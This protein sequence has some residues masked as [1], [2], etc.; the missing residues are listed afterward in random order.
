M[1]VSPVPAAEPVDVAEAVQK[2][3]PEIAAIR[4]RGWR[5][6]AISA[7]LSLFVLML[8]LQLRGES[9]FT[10]ILLSLA[11]LVI[12]IS[13]I[14]VQTRRNQEAIV[15]PLL[16]QSIGLNYS[17]KGT[18]FARSLPQRLL[19]KQG[20][21][22]GT[23]LIDGVIGGRSLTFG[24][25]ECATGGKNRRVLF[26]GVVARFQNQTPLPPFFLVQATRAGKSTLVPVGISTDGLIKIA[27]RQPR[28][29][30]EIGI[31]ASH[32]EVADDPALDAVVGA[33]LDLPDQLGPDA[34][35]YAA[36]CDGTVV[37]VALSHPKD[38]FRFGGMFEDDDDLLKQVKQALQ[39]LMMPMT[40]A[41]KLI[42]AEALADRRKGANPAAAAPL[43]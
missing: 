21:R 20:N 40:L 31:W 15:M 9:R 14:F 43:T 3:L 13:G 24:E 16:A 34:S 1:T 30:S 36:T 26:R 41:E 42:E 35:L 27:Q 2:I 29:D 23:D 39:D 7:A 32:A 4:G 19:P 22:T 10:L 28:A 8:S 12:V 18:E 11:C 6:M 33:I 5:N 38:L 25:V 17:Q 37:H